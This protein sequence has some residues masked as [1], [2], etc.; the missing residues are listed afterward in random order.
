MRLQ[1]SRTTN[2]ATIFC[3]KHAFDLSFD[4]FKQIKTQLQFRVSFQKKKTSV[5]RGRIN[6][7]HF[8]WYLP[9]KASPGI[10][11]HSMLGHIQCGLELDRLRDG[12]NKKTLFLAYRCFF[13]L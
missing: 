6:F 1:K 12:D 10:I 5:Q 9:G 13:T 2:Y 4:L 11:W 8:V 3:S 7:I